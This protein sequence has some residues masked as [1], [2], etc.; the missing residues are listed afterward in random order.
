MQVGTVG[1]EVGLRHADGGFS[2]CDCGGLLQRV[3]NVD[4]GYPLGDPE[5]GEYVYYSLEESEG[6]EL[7]DVIVCSLCDLRCCLSFGERPGLMAEVLG[8]GRLREWYYIHYDMPRFQ[9][10]SERYGG[11]KKRRPAWVPQPWQEAPIRKLAA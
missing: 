10:R 1:S 7:T 4:W 2:R 11:S 8:S 5:A 3:V 9:E 6:A